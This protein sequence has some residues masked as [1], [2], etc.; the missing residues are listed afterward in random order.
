MDITAENA[1]PARALMPDMVRAVSL[2][3]IA[4]VNVMGFSWAFETGFFNGAIRSPVDEMANGALWSLFAM[5]FYALFSM[6]FGA[7]LAYQMHSAARAKR[8]FATRYFRRMAGLLIIG[9]VHFTFFWMGDILMAYALFGTLFF[10]MKDFKT[11]TYIRLGFILILANALLLLL[12]AGVLL[13]V[14]QAG[15]DITE[16]MSDPA[17]NPLTL[18]AERLGGD[19][20]TFLSAAL[21]RASVLLSVAPS[22]MLQQGLGILGFFCFGLAAVR[23]NAID[24]PNHPVW[25]RAR[26]QM[27]PAGLVFSVIGG[28][29]ISESPSA[30]SASTIFGTAILM[31]ASPLLA[32]GY[33]GLIAKASTG[34]PGLIRRFI[35]RAGSASLS[36]YLLQSVILSFVF[37]G[38]GL[39][40]HSQLSAAQAIGVGALVGITSLIFAGTCRSFFSRGPMEVLLRKLT[41]FGEK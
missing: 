3:G 34:T 32:V 15:V 33:A 38:Y 35:A 26:W 11:R 8:N 28:W 12:F 23:S 10:A 1:P 16:L 24:D 2:F 9:I 30:I 7:G 18:E 17:S 19:Q 4:V 22:L 27:L 21:F 5:K 20:A 14:E 25:R 39:G 29:I 40:L 37:C 13:L 6:M 31:A 36:A 41:Y